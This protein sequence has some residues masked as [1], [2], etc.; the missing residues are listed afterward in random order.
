VLRRQIAFYK[1]YAAVNSAINTKIYSAVR[2]E[3]CGKISA[4]AVLKKLFDEMNGKNFAFFVLCRLNFKNPA[5]ILEK[6]R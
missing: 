3:Y 4:P 1:A 5:Y 2:R 6:R